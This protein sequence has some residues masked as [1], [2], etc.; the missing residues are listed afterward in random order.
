[1]SNRLILMVGLPRSGKSTIAKY[2]SK[3]WNAPI[4]N[5]DSI[6]LVLHG[7]AYYPP[8]EPMVWAIAKTM[9]RALFA[10]GHDSV[11]IDACNNTKHRRDEWKSWD[12]EW[13]IEI[14]VV[15]ETMET[16]LERAG[17]NQSLVDTI[18]RMAKQHEHPD[19][20]ESVEE[21]YSSPELDAKEMLVKKSLSDTVL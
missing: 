16:L 5:P 11:I 2:I 15:H 4:V 18:E 14:V 20:T 10:A 8:A 6:R 12:D 1:M 9:V 13:K 17:D 21:W 3:K 19:H 7:Q